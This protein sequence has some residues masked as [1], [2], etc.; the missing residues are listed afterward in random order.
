MRKFLFLL[1]LVPGILFVRGSHAQTSQERAHT[2]NAAVSGRWVVRADFYGTPIAFSL[3]LQQDGEKLTGNFQGDPL[4]GSLQGE[5]ISFLVK[6]DQ[7]RTVDFKG[8]IRDNT[9]SG[10]AVFANA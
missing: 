7:G 5:T 2:A 8:T 3:K 10:T 1:F 4:D 9:I 6:R